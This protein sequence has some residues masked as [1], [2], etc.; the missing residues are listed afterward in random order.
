MP[1]KEEEKK[2]SLGLK[3]PQFIRR[4]GRQQRK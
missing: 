3:I 4:G 2:R 1:L